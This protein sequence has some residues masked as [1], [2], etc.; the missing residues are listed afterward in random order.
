MRSNPP[1][2]PPG[3]PAG[4]RRFSLALFVFLVGGL[5]L[6]YAY[7]LFTIDD[8]FITL[9]YADHLA[10]GLGPVFN[11]GER[12][13]G[14]SNPL[15]MA[16]LSLF[17]WFPG[18]LL[19]PAKFLSAFFYLAT[20]WIL[21]RKSEALGL[22][23]WPAAA[24]YLASLSLAVWG[25]SG[26]ETSLFGFLLLLWA[27]AVTD[28]QPGFF[29]VLGLALLL[30]TAR[31]EAPLP[32]LIGFALLAWKRQLP[33]L[34]VII[35]SACAVSL[36]AARWAY[37]G[38]ILPNTYYA[39]HFQTPARWQITVFGYL[40]RYYLGVGLIPLL[41]VIA[42][43]W[44]RKSKRKTPG[45]DE[46]GLFFLSL[47]PALFSMLVGGDW[48]PLGRFL[49]PALP[50]SIWFCVRTFACARTFGC[51]RI[52][53][54][55][56]WMLALAVHFGINWKAAEE[57]QSM[58]FSFPSVARIQS[59]SN[60]N[61]NY[62]KISAWLDSL[63]SPPASLAVEEL[64]YFCDYFSGPCLDLH[65]LTDAHIAHSHQYPNSV[66]GK[67]LPLTDPGFA[68]TELGE[69]VLKWNP[70]ILILDV[71]NSQ[72]KTDSLLRGHYRLTT[73]IGNFNLYRR[74]PRATPRDNRP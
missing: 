5:F 70:E 59:S 16:L 23:P 32:L 43:F 47:W 9:R 31:P 13:E 45:K 21:I 36:L 2:L 14:Y 67:S 53:G 71:R 7:F 26:M 10:R 8:T 60:G 68:N 12:V 24:M 42:A 22:S 1:E 15:W 72:E 51:G 52:F 20:G 29:R 56:L 66:I 49:A 69:Y 62:R 50:V 63:P 58:D 34:L 35:F 65:G 4:E 33:F 18:G 57:V 25:V 19:L 39:K 11:P 27:L 54:T 3:T 40:R 73:A 74:T 17:A 46:V 55:V 64:G 28:A 38:D 41:G 37:Y 30:L 48:M 44:K 6:V 61:P